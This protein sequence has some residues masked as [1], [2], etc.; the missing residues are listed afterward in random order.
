MENDLTEWNENRI[1]ISFA[2]LCFIFG[3]EAFNKVKEY[4]DI[5]ELI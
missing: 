1:K 4:A 5:L 2:M 3:T